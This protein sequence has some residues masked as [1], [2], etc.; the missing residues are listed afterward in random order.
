MF[1]LTNNHENYTKSGTSIDEVKR[2]NDQS[3]LTYNEVKMGLANAYKNKELI[4]QKQVNNV[5]RS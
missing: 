5:K 3:G 4:N 2:K 1:I